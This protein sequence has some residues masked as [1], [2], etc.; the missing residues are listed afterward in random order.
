[1]TDLTFTMEH[2]G[3]DEEIEVLEAIY[4]EELNITKDDSSDVTQ[5]M[6]QLHP[7]TGDDI[8]QRFVCM[9]LVLS[10][11]TKYPDELPDITIRNP[12]GI[13]EEEIASLR[14]DMQVLCEERRGS[15]M[16]YELIELA[17]DSLTAGNIPHCLCMICLEH[18][19]EGEKFTKTE[20]YHYF[21]EDCLS[22][23]VSHILTKT[24]EVVPSHT[25]PTEPQSKI[26]CPVCRESIHVELSDLSTS[27]DPDNFTYIPSDD[28][29]QLQDK[30]AAVL[31]RQKACG[32][33]IDVEA[34]KNKFLVTN[35]DRVV[36]QLP[37]SKAASKLDTSQEFRSRGSNRDRSPRE[38]SSKTD[39]TISSSESL[40]KSTRESSKSSYQSSQ[41]YE[42]RPRSGYSRG[43]EREQRGYGKGYRDYDKRIAQNDKY[44]D[45]RYGKR[46]DRTDYRDR[47]DKSKQ[48]I[49]N[50]SKTKREINDGVDDEDNDYE[51]DDYGKENENVSTEEI[52]DK[53]DNELTIKDDVPES[54][55]KLNSS[56]VDDVTGLEKE[57]EKMSKDESGLMKEKLQKESD[58]K[59]GSKTKDGSEGERKDSKRY[60]N[61]ND[62]F[63][64]TRNRKYDRSDVRSGRGYYDGRDGKDR[65]RDGFDVPDKSHYTDNKGNQRGAS[66][67]TNSGSYRGGFNRKNDYERERERSDSNRNERRPET[68]RNEK[69]PESNRI[70]NDSK[71]SI[72]SNDSAKNAYRHEGNKSYRKDGEGSGMFDKSTDRRSHHYQN[73]SEPI[74][75]DS[76][77]STRR[78]GF[79]KPKRND[80][81]KDSSEVESEERNGFKASPRDDKSY[82]GNKQNYNNYRKYGPKKYHGR[83]DLIKIKDK[84]GDL[85]K[86]KAY[87][88]HCCS[89][90]TDRKDM[91][92]DSEMGKISEKSDRS[93]SESSKNHET[94]D[95]S[96][97]CNKNESSN[98]KVRAPPGFKVAPP[99]G[100]KTVNNNNES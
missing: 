48:Y 47:K 69:R 49:S 55:S 18:F 67:E 53:M 82:G 86:D 21:H 42:R 73:D 36:L 62:R 1:M 37:Q 81:V 51:G 52:I 11:T 10:L 87:S 26:V 27:N 45:N 5:I 16:L 39:R 12:R 8:E 79:G 95:L 80:V 71:S 40:D 14:E 29:K 33:I 88:K 13:A 84:R 35:Q 6:L 100:F 46:F 77:T 91:Y 30:M 50:N 34:E 72:N 96:K 23:Y 74:T 4:V 93:G 32:G 54:N 76:R 60:G 25:M 63:Y 2:G 89:E 99:P 17:K 28:I 20:C 22:R 64:D 68:K 61:R 83:H 31:Q 85:D 38:M 15:P 41:Q 94:G 3:L 78:G 59:D 66:R 58:K 65:K 70:E 7:A 97:E 90:V 44:K 56:D 75:D 19:H 9:T 92:S 57:K 24:P 98:T 43:N